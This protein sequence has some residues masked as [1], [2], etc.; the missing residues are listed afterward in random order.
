[1]GIAT[2]QEK[3]DDRESV[4]DDTF[5]TA[6]V[7]RVVVGVERLRMRIANDVFGRADD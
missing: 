3:R 4:Y 7:Y 6:F 2:A 5:F 1:M